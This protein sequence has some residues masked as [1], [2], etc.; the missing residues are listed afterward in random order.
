MSE[1]V[2][3]VYTDGTKGYFVPLTD[4]EVQ[5]MRTFVEDTMKR[6][7]DMGMPLEIPTVES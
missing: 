6:F 5:D 1:S 2:E 3:V 4:E 7:A